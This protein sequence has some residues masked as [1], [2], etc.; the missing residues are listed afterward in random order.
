IEAAGRLMSTS[1]TLMERSQPYQLLLELARGKL[2]QLRGQAAGWQENGMRLSGAVQ[3]DIR[4]ANEA[5]SQAVAV[6]SSEECQSAA[7][8]ALTVSYRAADQLVHGYID[9]SLPVRRQRQPDLQTKLGCRVS[10]ALADDSASALTTAFGRISIAFPW[11]SI[12]P[13][14]GCYN[15]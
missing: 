9:E 4:S 6:A 5:M 3:A 14:E 12:E 7:Q 8:L 15:W 10:T 1:A 11:S 2:N 13:N